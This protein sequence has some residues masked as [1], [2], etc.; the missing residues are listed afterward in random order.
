MAILPVFAGGD[1]TTTAGAARNAL[2]VDRI[3]GG[4]HLDVEGK[5]CGDYLS[6]SG[7]EITASCF[8]WWNR[9]YN[10]DDLITLGNHTTGNYNSTDRRSRRRYYLVNQDRKC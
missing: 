8:R 1:G 7:Q 4:G 10:L 3:G 9:S 5:L 2:G 6:I